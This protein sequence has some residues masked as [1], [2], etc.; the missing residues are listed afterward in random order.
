MVTV[1]RTV[2]ITGSLINTARATGTTG[3]GGTASVSAQDTTVVIPH[4][5]EIALTKAPDVCEVQEGVPTPVNYA[6]VISN[7]SDF[8]DV[9]NLKLV[10]DNGTPGSTFDDVTVC[11]PAPIPPLGSTDCSHTFTLSTSRTNVA[12]ASGVSGTAS[13]TATATATVGKFSCV[14]T[15]GYPSGPAGSRTATVF[16]ESGVLRTFS[17]GAGQCAVSINDAI[18]LWYSDEHALSLG[19]TQSGCAGTVSPFPGSPGCLTAPQVGCRPTAGNLLAG[20]D[21]FG[22]PIFPALFITDVTADPSANSGDWQQDPGNNAKAQAPSRVCGTWKTASRNPTTG[23]ITVGADPAKN[24][25]AGIPDAPPG[26]FASISSE[27][28]GA[29]VIWNVA[30]LQV[31]GQPIQAGHTYRAQFMVHDGDQNKGG[32]DVGQ[33]CAIVHI[34]LTAPCVPPVVAV[35]AGDAQ[36]A[37]TQAPA[38][39]EAAAG[40]TQAAE[41]PAA[42]GPA[43]ADALELYRATPNPFRETM[44]FA[45]AVSGPDAQAVRVGVY[46]VAGRQV[47]ALAGGLMAPGRYESRWDGRNDA[48]GNVGGGIYFVRVVAGG[49]QVAFRVLYL[50]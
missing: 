20:T 13:V 47:R 48:G 34:P 38:G 5:C 26:G 33:A 32:G 24:V 22:R 17:P 6:Y 43:I 36:A 37:A 3:P 19:V 23:V 11:T 44:R 49:K 45:Y 50:R 30:D 1:P 10:D 21:P 29:E 14:C 16:N 7:L 39:E 41:T 46:D 2:N 15:L 27:G 18:R 8:F 9:H 35:V 12:T 4:R 42:Q 40:S 28:Y 31:D 25:W